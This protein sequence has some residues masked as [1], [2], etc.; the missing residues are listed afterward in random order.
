MDDKILMN[1]EAK[2]AAIEEKVLQESIN[3]EKVWMQCE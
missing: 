1:L 3:D 2:V